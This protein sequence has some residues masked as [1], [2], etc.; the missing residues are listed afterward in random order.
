MPAHDALRL[1]EQ[2]VVVE[3][4]ARSLQRIDDLVV[5][6]QKHRLQLAD[7]VVLVVA[8]VADQRATVDVAWE[9]TLAFGLIGVAPEQE[10]VAL[11]VLIQ[12]RLVIGTAAVQ[13]VQIEAWRAEI[14]RGI[15]IVLLLQGA[16]RI[17]GEIVID[18][19]PEVGVSGW[20]RGVFIA[21]FGVPNCVSSSSV[22]GGSDWPG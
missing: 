16:I 20:D 19:L 13:G 3:R 17:E 1:L 15:R 7:D 4:R 12:I 10:A 8:R 2:L 6:V 9:L 11:V 22:P 5:K 14:F 18:E 21:G